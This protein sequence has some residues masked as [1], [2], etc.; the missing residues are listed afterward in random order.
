[1]PTRSSRGLCCFPDGAFVALTVTQNRK[2]PVEISTP[3]ARTHLR[4]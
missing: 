3:E 4:T 1:M 2:D